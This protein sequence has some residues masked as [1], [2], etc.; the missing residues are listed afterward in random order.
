[1][2]EVMQ[3]RDYCVPTCQNGPFIPVLRDCHIDASAGAMAIAVTLLDRFQARE[4]R[5]FRAGMFVALGLYGL[6]PVLHQV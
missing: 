4:W 1:M 6:A 3:E 5:N 2:K